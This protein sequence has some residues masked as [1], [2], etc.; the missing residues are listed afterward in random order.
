MSSRCTSSRSGRAAALPCR[1]PRP[2]P[3]RWWP[4]RSCR[5]PPMRASVIRATGSFD[6]IQLTDVPDPSPGPLGPRDVR[7]AIRAAALNHLDLFVVRGL[8]H[9]Y[10]YPHILGAD[11]AGAVEA[12][13]AQVRSVRPGDRVMINPGIPDDSCVYC[14]A[15]EHSL[16]LN[17]GILGE[18]LPGTLAQAIVVPEQNVAVIP[19]LPMPLTWAEAAAFSLVTLTAWRM[20]V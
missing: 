4:P 8:P 19:T 13:G 20:I 16:C 18:H 17:Y 12:V 3:S 11:G 2:E 1:S 6:Q 7:V 14:R 9:E 15:G 5:D 10:R